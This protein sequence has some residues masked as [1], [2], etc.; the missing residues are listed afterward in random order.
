M[1]ND[2]ALKLGLAAFIVFI[3]FFVHCPTQKERYEEYF[4]DQEDEGFRGDDEEGFD[5]Y[6]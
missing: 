6:E 1:D 4:R 3:V 2:S 5:D